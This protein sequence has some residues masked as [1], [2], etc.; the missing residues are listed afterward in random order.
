MAG[1]K[2]NK[3]H[4]N[5][6][7]YPNQKGHNKHPNV[8]FRKFAKMI[9]NT[10]DDENILC[11]QDAC[12]SIDW[13]SSKVEYWCKKIP[14]FKNLKKDI[15]DIIISR[16]NKNALKN[17]FNA[18]ASIWRMKQLGEKDKI[19]HER[20]GEQGLNIIVQSKKQADDI[21]DALNKT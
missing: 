14:V 5:K 8:V 17:K 3:A 10:K 7:S 21:E 15:Q 6:T 16:I 13:R 2:G 12:I 11:F 9:Q 1:K 4:A 19:E 20:S 18:T